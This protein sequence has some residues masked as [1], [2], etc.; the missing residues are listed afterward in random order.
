MFSTVLMVALT[1]GVDLPDGHR[2]GGGRHGC[3][4]GCGS[5][6]GYGGCGYG[7]GCGGGSCYGGGCGGGYCSTGGCAGGVCYGGGSGYGVAVADTEAPVRIVVS[8]PD[9]AKLTIDDYATTSTSGNRTFVSPALA[10]G[11]DY[12]YTLKAK[13]TRDGKPVEVEKKITV[14]AG[15]ETRVNFDLPTA[16]AA[17]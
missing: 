13:V 3:H 16:V 1:A 15:E 7:G 12:H 6:C 8:L 2:C 14:R 17:R 4:G 11:R 9:D 5:S 10:L